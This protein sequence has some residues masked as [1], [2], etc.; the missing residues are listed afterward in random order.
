[1]AFDGD[2]VIAYKVNSVEVCSCMWSNVFCIEGTS[3]KACASYHGTLTA[4]K[5]TC[6]LCDR[7]SVVTVF[8]IISF[9]F[10]LL[11]DWRMPVLSMW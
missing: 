3:E 6:G 2:T 5:A 8:R 7:M 11:C 9:G 10:L 4:N 1:M